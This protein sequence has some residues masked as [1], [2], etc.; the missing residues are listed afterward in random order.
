[1]STEKPLV[2]TELCIENVK[3]IRAVRIVPDGGPTQVIGG[4]NAM[5][6]TSTLDSIEMA[7]GGGKAIP[8][9]PLR[10]GARKGKAGVSLGT[11][12]EPPEFIVERTFAADGSSQLVVKNAEGVPQKTPQKLLDALCAAISFDPFAFT[13]LEPKKQDAIL[14]EALGLDFTDI[15]NRRAAA[16][17]ER[18]EIKRALKDAEALYA[19][20]P[21]HSGVPAKEQSVSDIAAMLSAVREAQSARAVAE[22]KIEAAQR[23]VDNASATVARIEAELASAKE[24]LAREMEALAVRQ[25]EL[26]QLP[27]AGDAGELETKLR[28][29]EATNAKVRANL[30]RE[31]AAKRLSELEKKVKSLTEKIEL[32]DAEKHNKLADTSFPVPGLGFDESGPTLNGVPLEQASSAEQ[33][34]VSVAIGLALNPRLRVLLIREGSLLDDDSMRMLAEIATEAGAQLWVEK[35]SSTGDGCSVV[36]EDGEVK[37]SATAAE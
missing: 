34:R 19:A 27:P 37:Q 7:I 11:I 30:A 18:T 28:E 26:S 17:Q 20:M 13:R 15:D 14:K 8:Q 21:D 3:R 9:E 5:G 10:R 32:A 23:M 29:A 31:S 4:R 16:F 12:G 33:L 2:I 1:M 22:S 36:I 6:K 25:G 35:V 24:R